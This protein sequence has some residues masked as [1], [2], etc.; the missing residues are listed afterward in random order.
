MVGAAVSALV[1]WLLW[2]LLWNGYL[3][4]YWLWPLILLTP[5][6]AFQSMY[7]V[8]A[9][10]TYYAIVLA[11]IVIFFGRLG[12]WP[13]VLR[14]LRK[15][16]QGPAGTPSLP[17]ARPPDP[18]SDPAQWPQMR[19]DGA[20]AVADRLTADLRGGRM[21]DVDQARIDHAWRSGRNRAEITAEV[22]ER[23]AAACVH[24]S[25]ARD[26][27][28]RVA[29]HDLT[30][31]QVRLGVGVDDPER[32]ARPYRG[33]GIAVDPRVLG[34]SGVVVGPSDADRTTRIV[35]PVVESLC[36][37]ALTGQAAVVA[38]A[39]TRAA[40]PGT[41]AFDVVITA[42]DPAAAYC[43][44]LYAGIDDPDEAAG[45]IAEALIGDL[46]ESLPGGDSRRAAIPLAQLMGAWQAVHGALPGV[47]D[48]RDLVDDSTVRDA[49]RA[50]LGARG[51]TSHLRELEAFERRADAS[52]DV[53]DALSNRIALLDRPAFESLLS[54]PGRTA[55]RQVFSLQHLDRP[56]RVRVD[57]PE[58]VHAEASRI[59]A[60]LLLAQFCLWAAARADRGLYAG[61]VVDDAVQLVTPQALRGLQ[62]LR[63]S[64]A[65]VLL[66]L[67]TL[68]DV[69]A[70]LRDPL[71]GAVGC[72]IACAGVNPWDAQHFA[73]AW[74]TEWVETRTVTHR[75]VRAEEP[76]TKVWH[77]IRR[78]VTGRYVTSEAVTV[79]REE[80]QRWSASELAHELLPGHAVMSFSTVAGERTPPILTKLDG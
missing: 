12:N 40:T 41:A 57:L 28:G 21:S 23:G 47:A 43:L 26:L 49:L 1:G 68:A 3:G 64:N 6:D 51:L 53:L 29:R 27:A 73:S 46:S 45:L 32:Q 25:G 63:M 59:V 56:V 8:V 33:A 78:L 79:R 60:R 72:R 66:A 24:G 2:S 80:R 65:G 11:V 75:E 76:L 5:D 16:L 17:S 19:A 44:D 14:R 58:R 62:R 67:R 10:W 35:Y 42:G 20:L 7:F 77:G 54:V 31:G 13:E 36:L 18:L 37:Q 15:K 71:L 70:S 22:L 52:G 39:S 30:V 9:S 55:G 74:G 50:D 61:L 34:T 4:E 69:P 48:L 38:V